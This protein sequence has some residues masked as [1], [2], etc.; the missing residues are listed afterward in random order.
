MIEWAISAALIPL[1]T[2]IGALTARVE[3]CEIVQGVTSE[4]TTLKAE[5]SDLRKDV[6]YL[7]STD[8][9]SLFGLVEAPG[10]PSSSNMSPATAGDEPMDDVAATELE[11]EMDE[12]MFD[13]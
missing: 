1:Q 11:A 4:V 7:K 6:D 9:T 5:V 13:A 3:T 12:E 10:V 2:L 8:F